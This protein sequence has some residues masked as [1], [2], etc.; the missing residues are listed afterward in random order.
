MRNTQN[1]FDRERLLKS[2]KDHCPK[3]PNHFKPFRVERDGLNRLLTV[4][5]I[6]IFIDSKLEIN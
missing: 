6:T 1:T 2:S 4:T 5:E 3:T